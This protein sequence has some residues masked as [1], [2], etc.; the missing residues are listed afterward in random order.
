MKLSRVPVL[1]I[2]A[3]T[4][5]AG[6]CG[7]VGGANSVAKVSS[8]E[9]TVDRLVD[10]LNVA[11]VPLE[12]EIVRSV[13][14]LWVNYQLAGVAAARSDT[15]TSTTEMNAGLWSAIDN[16]RVRL[17][18]DQISQTWS[19]DTAAAERFYES[20]EILSAR[21]ILI[22][23]GVDA[24]PDMVEAARQKA[25]AIRREATP[26]NFVRLAARSDEPGAAESGGDLGVFAP[27]RM[28]PEFTAGVLATRPGE[29]SEVV[30][31]DYGFHVIY[32]KPFSEVRDQVTEPARQRSLIKAESTYLAGIEDAADV[33][34]GRNA[35]GTVKDIARNP[36]DFRKN[37]STIAEFKGGK[38]TASRTADWVRAYPP[39]QQIRPQLINADDSLA[40]RF[41]RSVVRNELLLRIADSAGIVVDSAEVSN[42]HMVFRNNLTMAWTTIGIEPSTLADSA[43]SAG[44]REKVAGRHIDAYFDKLVRNE[45]QFADIAYPVAHALQSKYSFSISD[46]GIE[47]AI[48]RARQLRT[49]NPDP[50]AMPPAPPADPAPVEA[51]PPSN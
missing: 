48:E 49:E 37:N 33:K 35:A 2:L 3:V 15:I 40:E 14:E 39:Q 8:Q 28:V 47:R 30:R 11:Q 12:P 36:L 21:H 23:A 18:Y 50:A 9:L 7:A 1:M 31:S 4:A 34:L 42:L 10:V 6:A 5:V 44:E 51:T 46:A 19:V 16:S 43:T 32:R 38:L 27:E 25:E 22:Q 20:G 26:A 41:V 17:L 13:A 45:V 29:I 24:P